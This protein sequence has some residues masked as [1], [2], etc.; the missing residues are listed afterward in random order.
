MEISSTLELTAS[1][2][3]HEKSGM[4]YTITRLNKNKLFFA[5]GASVSV[6]EIPEKKPV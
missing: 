2:K 1:I 6:E 4:T 3:K 5:N